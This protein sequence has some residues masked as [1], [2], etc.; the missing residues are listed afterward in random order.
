[1]RLAV[2]IARIKLFYFR[3]IAGQLGLCAKDIYRL[4]EDRVRDARLG[5]DT[6]YDVREMSE[7]SA[8]RDEVLYRPTSYHRLY[9]L[10]AHWRPGPEDVLVD[11]GCGKGRALAVGALGGFTKVIGV[12]LNSRLADAAIA[13]LRKLNMPPAAFEVRAQDALAF[14]PAQGTHFFLY[15]PFKLMTFTAVLE[16]I[17]RSLR[18]RPRPLHIAYFDPRYPELLDAQPWLRSEGQLGHSRIFLWRAAR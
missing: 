7:R 16:R 6:C 5:I 9:L 2:E 3:K 4:V 17:G 18:E 14:D 10:M 12:E 8:Y 13:N 1:M 15:D 11:V